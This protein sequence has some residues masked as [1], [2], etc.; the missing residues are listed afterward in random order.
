VAAVENPDLTVGE[1]D[2]ETKQPNGITIYRNKLAD[3]ARIKAV[4]DVANQFPEL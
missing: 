4:A 3:A 2:S 1:E